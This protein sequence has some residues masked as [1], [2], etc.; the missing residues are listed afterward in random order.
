MTE[1]MVS[2]RAEAL[3][4]QYARAQMQADL[5]IKKV[6]RPTKTCSKSNKVRTSAIFFDDETWSV[7]GYIPAHTMS[8]SM[9]PNLQELK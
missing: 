7:G 6:R 3:F 4:Q 9:A 2:K 1:K 8:D 5:L